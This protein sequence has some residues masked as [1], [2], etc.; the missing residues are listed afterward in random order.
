[1]SFLHRSQPAFSNAVR[2]L[3]AAGVLAMS[4]GLL[5][6][7][8]TADLSV[9]AGSDAGTVKPLLGVNVGPYLSATGTSVHVLGPYKDLGVTQVRTH[10]FYGPVDMYQMYPDDAADPSDPTN[11][12]FADSDPRVEYI[13]NNGHE[14]FL[15]IGNSYTYGNPPYNAAPPGNTN[16]WV[17]AAK[18]VIRH[19]R[20]GQWGGSCY[21]IRYIEIWNEPDNTQFWRGTESAFFRFYAQAAT[22]LKSEFP[23]LR[24]GGPGFVPSC[25]LMHTTYASNF[26]SYC[27]SNSVPLDFLS[28][29]LYSDVPS[30]FRDA[31]AYYRNLLDTHGYS[32]AENC[33]SE[34]QIET[35]GLRANAVGAALVTAAWI[36]LQDGEVDLAQLYR[37]Q[38]PNVGMD[39]FYGLLRADGSYKK[40]AYAFKAWSQFAHYP[41]RLSVS[42]SYTGLAVIAARAADARSLAVLLANCNSGAV[43][44]YRL[45]F[46]NFTGGATWR[47]RRYVVSPTNNLD[48]LEDADVDL[49]LPL[50]RNLPTNTVELLVLATR[51]AT[52]EPQVVDL[53]AIPSIV[54]ENFRLLAANGST[55]TNVAALQFRSGWTSECLRIAAPSN[56]A[57]QIAVQSCR[58]LNADPTWNAIAAGGTAPLMVRV[59]GGAQP[60]GPAYDV[61]LGC[62]E[63]QNAEF[64]QFLNDAE[65]APATS[66]GTNVFIQVLGPT[67]ECGD[68]YMSPTMA[69]DQ[70]LFDLSL[71]RL[72]YRTNQPVGQRYGI[73]ATAPA[74]GGSYS[75]HP[76]VGVTWF[77][78]AKYCNWLT[79]TRGGVQALRCYHEGPTPAAWYPIT[80]PSGAAFT[81]A[82]DTAAREAW[83]T[84]AQVRLG[85]RLPMTGPSPAANA[86][87]EF[88]RAAAWDGAVN[89][90]YPWGRNTLT[91]GDANYLSSGDPF[92]DD[93]TP[94]G[95]YDGVNTL[96][97]G[98][99]TRANENACRIYDL[100]GNVEEW[101]NDPYPAASGYRRVFGGHCQS[102]T[103]AL[104]LFAWT[105][106]L[107]TEATATRGFRIA[108]SAVR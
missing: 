43:T 53:W 31:G 84:N 54:P 63:I 59:P 92:A 52:P 25:Y 46:T 96:S 40:P 33:I 69:A 100:G 82:F 86:Y 11:Y 35:G 80:L 10:D 51:D 77:G 13:H 104:D 65:A 2:G 12:V 20:E 90:R 64:A 58:S 93:T 32:N 37:G 39:G 95:Y 81:N 73:T 74:G 79:V 5:R 21:P 49:E 56:A 47:A 61:Y 4:A 94:V 8:E 108:A 98:G 66:R 105:N 22:T 107:P 44:N 99:A 41:Y 18:N 16:H 23:D 83:R 1:M 17:E 30:E 26:L 67:N 3:T 60:T 103:N 42:G 101:S 87:N 75:N 9:D 71:S 24:I 70:L 7:G 48:L 72:E 97:D 78:A 38:D 106:A 34:W 89:T 62:Y 91:N 68:A 28:W 102:A 27:Q 76:V 55:I 36:A 45:S 88:F 50:Q 19:Y 6:A 57:D 29:H 85:F 14:I 15:R